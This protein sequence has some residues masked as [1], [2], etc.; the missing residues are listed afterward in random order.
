MKKKIIVLTMAVAFLLAP[1]T[2]AHGGHHGTHHSQT[3]SHC[4]E[5]YTCNGYA[6]HQHNNGVCPYQTHAVERESII[7]LENMDTARLQNIIRH[8]QGVMYL[9]MAD[10]CAYALEAAA[11]CELR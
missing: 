4:A 9:S 6:E 8:C 7:S 3:Y 1:A 5:T 2:Y 10:H 11:C